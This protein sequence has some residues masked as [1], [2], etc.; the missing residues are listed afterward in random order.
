[1]KLGGLVPKIRKHLSEAR[2]EVEILQKSFEK[3]D[4]EIASFEA[5]H[6]RI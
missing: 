1:M 4:E 6:S 2:Y 5:C 3:R